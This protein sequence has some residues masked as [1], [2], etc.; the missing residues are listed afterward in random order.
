MRWFF[1]SLLLIAVGGGA[2]VD[3]PHSTQ[4]PPEVKAQNDAL[5][6]KFGISGF[7]TLLVIDGNE[8]VLGQMAG[9]NPGSGPGPVIAQLQSFH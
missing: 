2:Y 9:Y 1:L 8:H 7:P 5:Q 6:R 3:F 4:L